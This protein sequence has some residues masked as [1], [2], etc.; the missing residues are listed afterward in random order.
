VQAASEEAIELG[1]SGVPAWVIDQR[2]LV[3]GAQPHEVFDQVMERLGYRS[4]G[5]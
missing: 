1:V 3:P 4:A 5:A 2:V